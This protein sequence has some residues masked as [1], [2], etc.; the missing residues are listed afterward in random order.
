[1]FTGSD[2]AT[3]MTV[4]PPLGVSIF[5]P[6]HVLGSEIGQDPVRLKNLASEARDR[7]VSGGLQRPEA[8][9]FVAPATAL[10]DDHEFW[11]H[12]DQ[13]LAVFLGGADARHFKVP[14]PLAER[15]VVGPG[16]HVKPLLPVLAADGAFLLLTITADKVRLF[17]ASRFSLTETAATDLPRGI[18]EDSPEPD[19]E[20]PVQASPVA[21]PHTGV[22]NI[23]NAQV[24]GGS[25]EEWRKGRLVE[26]VR[27]VAAAMKHRF[28]ANPVPVVV[29]ADAEIGGH[30]QK[31][32]SLGSLLA[33]VI[34]VNPEAIEVEQLHE[35]AYAVMRPRLEEGRRD[36][37]ERLEAL[38]GSGDG[39]AVTGVENVVKAA[40]GGRVEAL[41]LVEGDS[42]WGT[43]D[44]AADQVLTG[45][46]FAAA[47]QDLLDAAAV[48]TLQHAGAVYLL[49]GDDIPPDVASVAAVLR[50]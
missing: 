39:R 41:L 32:S 7:L 3:L 24:Y 14:V 6:T 36:A 10:V 8:E 26:F 44:E 19:Y 43:F 23:G 27:K 38:R 16:F 42:A 22:I 30:F 29:A 1:M 21:R 46:G 15:V 33:G 11:Q 45:D 9:A 20:N 17:D 48:Q 5:L 13:G 4:T 40:Y 31:F 37:V 2:L 50:Y 47:G 18:G 49:S 25:P 12:Q 35:A 28:A 34:E